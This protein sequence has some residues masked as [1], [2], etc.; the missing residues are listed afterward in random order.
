MKSKLT[1]F[2]I[3]FLGMGL[4]YGILLTFSGSKSSTLEIF[5]GAIFFGIMWGLAEVFVFP[6]IRNRFKKKDS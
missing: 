2:I 5:K 4:F 1:T 3:G 6:W